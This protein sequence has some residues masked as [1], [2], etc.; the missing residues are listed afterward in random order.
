MAT[1]S[2]IRSHGVLLIVIIGLAMLAFILEGLLTSGNSFFNRNRENIAVIAGHNVH[3]TE[4]D[5]AKD[6]LTQ[7]AKMQ[8]QNP[9]DESAQ[10]QIRNQVWQMLMMQY[11]L[12]DEAEKI[13]LAVAPTE[14]TELCLGANPH[15]IIR[16]V[17]GDA[18]G[19]ID[20]DQLAGF[21]Q[22]I[23]EDSDN[24]QEQE[25]ILSYRSYWSYWEKVVRLTQL[26]D[27]YS[28]LVKGL[29]RANSLDAKF[30]FDAR[31][32]DV[33]VEYVCKPYYPIPDSLVQVSSADIKK[34]YKQHKENYKR[35]PNR[36]IQYVCFDIVPS[37]SDFAEV[38]TFME[39]LQEEFKTTDNIAAVV[40]PNSEIPFEGVDYSEST[41]PAQ[42]KDFAFAKG[43][44]AG[45]VTDLLFNDAN[46]TYSMARIMKA[47]YSLPD[48]VELKYIARQE[49]EEDRELGW[50]MA[51]ELSKEIAEPAFNSKKGTRFTV[52]VGTGEQTFEVLE[53]SKATPKVQLAILERKVSASSKTTNALYNKINQLI[54]E[55][56]TE[57]KFVAAMLENNYTVTPQY[58]L[59][60]NTEKIGT[61]ESSRSIIQWAFN[62]K[63]GE[64]S[65]LFQCG[66]QYVAAVLTEVNEGEYSSIEEVISDLTLEAIN[67]KKAEL[68]KKDLAGV[69]TLAEA[70]DKLGVNVQTAEHINFTSY[71][72]GGNG[73]EPAVV[74]TAMALADN[75]VSEPIQGNIG[76]YIIKTGVKVIANNE[77]DIDAEKA[78]LDQRNA[79]ML[80]YQAISLVESEAQVT[81]NRANFY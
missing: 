14:L 26:Q 2:K 23:S 40:N 78:Q 81:D 47:G 62:A 60:Q 69:Q 12:G 44:K 76:V 67:N 48:S 73:S 41:V 65:K 37:E 29:V 28:A 64:V 50:F 8:G 4:F 79:Y 46:D 33:N 59:T 72:F 34:L 16:S 49:G 42:Y 27:K 63:E 70:A 21:I 35:E 3:F 43:A 39:N 54:A 61:L 80:P 6:Q 51:T 31:Q 66:N 18:E 55:N 75:S 19:N 45:Q 24:P 17:F 22:Q 56:Y 30:A 13:G 68:I 71:R 15:R 58:N 38:K 32:A 11:T 9:N 74:G 7:V 52:S 57:E 10:S 1:L 53:V 5:A 77:L 20:R 36:A 25:A